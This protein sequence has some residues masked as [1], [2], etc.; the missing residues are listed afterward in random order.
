MLSEKTWS[1]EA[2]ARL[3]LGVMGTLCFG[4]LTNGLIEKFVVGLTEDQR[5]FLGTVAMGLFFQV[6]A[7]IWITVFLREE[8][9]SW[10]EAF[11]FSSPQRGRA[12]SLAVLAVLV[13]LPIAWALT[14]IAFRIE[15]HYRVEFVPQVIVEQLQKPGMGIGQKIVIGI[16]AIVF[17]PIAE[18]SL[19]RGILYP[20]VKRAGYPKLA[21]WGTSFLFALVHFNKETFAPL[22][23][24]AIILTLLYE[25]TNNLLAPMVTHSLFN[26]TNFI[27]LIL[28]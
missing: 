5:R 17:A 13:F 15:T 11:G 2:V 22:L 20:T 21:F 10:A 25:E 19:F 1:P 6:S 26:A 12:I 28:Q 4:M 24:L 7:L 14:Q 18:E 3:F 9:L 16:I 8:K 27:Y 23:I